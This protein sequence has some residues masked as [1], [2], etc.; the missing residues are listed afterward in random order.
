VTKFKGPS[1][2]GG[3]RGKSKPKKV[4]V[5][6]C[7]GG[8]V[9]AE[10]TESLLGLVTESPHEILVSYAYSGP[11]IARSRNFLLSRFLASDKDYFLSVDT[12]IQ[13]QTDDLDRLLD[14]DRDIVSGLYYGLDR[15]TWDSFPVALRKREDGSLPPIPKDDLEL[16]LQQ[17][18]AVGMG[19]VLIRRPVVELLGVDLSGGFPF[20]ELVV[21]GRLY[22]E[23]ATFCT[24]AKEAGFEVWLQPEVR[25]GHKKSFII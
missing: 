9:D 2:K 5:G 22:G 15:N 17:V 1:P 16:G 4:M 10:F 13:F 8:T 19:F 11:L 20:G 24:R 6:Y 23:D 12:D 14:A 7:T 3:R 21:D 18:D 25:V